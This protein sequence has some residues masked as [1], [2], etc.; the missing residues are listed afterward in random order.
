MSTIIAH[1]HHKDV[2]GFKHET[3]LLFFPLDLLLYSPYIS[4][5]KLT[6]QTQCNAYLARICFGATYGSHG[7]SRG[8]IDLFK[9]FQFE[10]LSFSH[11][12]ESNLANNQTDN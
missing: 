5:P 12:Q 8:V 9:S 2:Q 4:W 6:N 7:N 10:D 11:F 3:L 1:E